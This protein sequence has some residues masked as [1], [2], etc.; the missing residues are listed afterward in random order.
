MIIPPL[1]HIYHPRAE[2]CHS[3]NNAAHYHTLGV[4]LW[5]G[6]W[7]VTELALRLEQWDRGSD[8]EALSL[9][10][11][12]RDL[13][14]RGGRAVWAWSWQLTTQCRRQECLHQHLRF[15]AVV[16][17]YGLIWLKNEFL[18]NEHTVCVR[19]CLVTTC[20]LQAGCGQQNMPKQKSSYEYC[21][22]KG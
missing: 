14:L 22:E 17:K 3:P 2:V 20:T 11:R 15:H 8:T 5:P 10:N 16:L 6:T 19:R 1:L 21:H 4:H 9:L 13:L 12:Y 7:L 18:Q